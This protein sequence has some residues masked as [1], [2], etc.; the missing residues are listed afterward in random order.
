MEELLQFLGCQDSIR[1]VGFEFIKGQFS[2]ICGESMN[3]TCQQD[4]SV[5]A[6]ASYEVQ[7]HSLYNSKQYIK[8]RLVL[9]W[10]V[11]AKVV[12]EVF[13]SLI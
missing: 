9:L 10:F 2:I 6:A 13:I 8:E 3:A 5:R 4:S 1:E 12:E 7:R 11:P